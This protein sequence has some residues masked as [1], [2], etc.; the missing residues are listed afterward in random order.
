M[1]LKLPATEDHYRGSIQVKTAS[2]EMQTIPSGIF[3]RDIC[4]VRPD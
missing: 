2:K 3:L 1:F 4:P